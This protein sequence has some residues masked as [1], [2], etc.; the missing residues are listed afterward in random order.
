M[1]FAFFPNQ[2]PWPMR[3]PLPWVIG[4]G[5]TADLECAA[6][7]AEEIGDILGG[8]VIVKDTMASLGGH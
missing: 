8:V 4:S 3:Q 2:R 1:W 5:K 7:W 6:R